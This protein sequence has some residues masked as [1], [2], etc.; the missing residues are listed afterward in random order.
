MLRYSRIG[1]TLKRTMQDKEEALKP[2]VSVLQS[3]GVS[4]FVDRHCIAECGTHADILPLGSDSGVDAIVTVGGDGTI[5]RAVREF[6]ELGVPFITINRGTLG[7]LAEIPVDSIDS[8]LPLLLEG[9]GVMESRGLL[10]VH[11]QRKGKRVYS[12]IA[13]NE[14]VIAQGAIARL[15]ELKTD[16]D[17]EELTTFDADGLIVATP[18]GSTAYSLAAGGPIVHPHLSAV[19]LTPINPHSFSQKPLV[20]PGHTSVQVSVMLREQSIATEVGLSLDGQEYF[21]L[22]SDDVVDLHL[23]SDSVHFL[24]RRADTFVQTLRQKLKWGE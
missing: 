22:S 4:V 8:C 6:W 15:I 13:L 20:L 18:T 23:Q 14:A 11:V 2:V 3:L 24:R 21:K 1:L 9:K 5:L 7:F 10:H 16:V 17:G 19:I 12:G